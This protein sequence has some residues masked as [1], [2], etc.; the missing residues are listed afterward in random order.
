M[1]WANEAAL[2]HARE[3][4]KERYPGQAIEILTTFDIAHAGWECALILLDG[5]PDL[6][7]VDQVG[8]DIRKVREIL[9]AKVKEYERL[10]VDSE[11]ALARYRDLVMRRLYDEHEAVEQTPE[12]VARHVDDM[13]KQ[14]LKSALELPESVME[15]LRALA[16]EHP[17]EKLDLVGGENLDF[18]PDRDTSYHVAR[19]AMRHRIAHLSAEIARLERQVVDVGV[20]MSG[21]D[22]RDRDA[23][24]KAIEKYRRR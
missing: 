7:I 18:D 22:Y 8:G 2:E 4:L 20:E 14:G 6:V 3:V 10:I 17:H 5:Q 15:R 24:E 16:D 13:R 19:E 23:I 21:L 9:E 12:I 1:T 11:R